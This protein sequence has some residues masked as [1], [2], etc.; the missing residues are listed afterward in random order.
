MARSVENL[1]SL[2][3]EVAEISAASTL[4]W[5]KSYHFTLELENHKLRSP[6]IRNFMEYIGP[7]DDVP[8]SLG[9]DLAGILPVSALKWRES[10]QL[11]SLLG[12]IGK[13]PGI[14]EFM[15][16]PG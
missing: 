10:G 13:T 8:I 3:A 7:G 5:R 9:M 12:I 2:Y 11:N 4:K 15:V 1:A 6:T 14:E 16:Y